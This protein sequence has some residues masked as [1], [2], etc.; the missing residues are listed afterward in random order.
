MQIISDIATRFRLAFL[1][2]LGIVGGVKMNVVAEA[3]P[4][5]EV[6]ILP[7]VLTV[8]E[9]DFVS[10]ALESGGQVGGTSFTLVFDPNALTYKQAEL[11]AG[12]TNGRLTV[13][14]RN[15]ADGQLGIVL[16]L[17]ADQT[18]ASGVQE[19]VRAEFD[20]VANVT[21]EETTLSFSDNPVRQLFGDVSANA[22]SGSFQEGVI[23]VDRLIQISPID[24]QTVP[25]DTVVEIPFAVTGR[26]SVLTTTPRSSDVNLVPVENMII[27]G[28]GENRVLKVT[29]RANVSGDVELG[30]VLTDGVEQ[31]VE[32]FRLT[33][34]PVNDPP[35]INPIAKVTALEN[36]GSVEI[37]LEGI[38]S[39]AA[40][41]SQLITISASSSDTK[42][43]PFIG[44]S[45]QSPDSTGTLRVRSNDNLNGLGVIA[46]TVTDDGTGNNSTTIEFE[47]EVTS[48]NTAPVVAPIPA[49]SI[50]EE[51]RSAVTLRAFDEDIP[52]DELRFSLGDGAPEGV[53]IDPV[54]GELSWTPTEE[55]GPGN[56]DISVIVTDDGTPP[57][58]TEQVFSVQVNEVN[59]APVLL[60]VGDRQAIEDET[61]EFTLQATDPD[62]PLN[63]LR[64]EILK[65][66]A[67]AQLDPISGLFSWTPRESDTPG[68]IEV[69]VGVRDQGTVP[70]SDSHTFFID[71]KAVNDGP[72]LKGPDSVL[73]DEDGEI[74][75]PDLVLQDSD[76]GEGNGRLDLRV[77]HGHL[78]VPIAG[79]D[80]QSALEGSES[81][82]STVS[83]VGGLEELQRILGEVVYL[84]NAN[85]H[86]RDTLV[87]EVSDE[88]N[89]GSGGA[90]SVS[91][92]VPIT[93]KSIND[94]PV[95]GPAENRE[96]IAG[97]VLAPVL[98]SVSDIEDAL[99]DL[100]FTATS[101][102]ESLVPDRGIELEPIDDF[103][104][105]TIRPTPRA[106]GEA[107]IRL[108]VEDL[109]GATAI[110]EFR[111]AMSGIAP[112]LVRQSPGKTVFAG[113]DVSFGVEVDGT[114]PF[115][116]TWLFAATRDEDPVVI[117]EAKQL[118]LTLNEVSLENVGY[119]AARV[120]NA[121]GSVV[122]VPV[123]LLVN[124]PPV[125]TTQPADVIASEGTP[126]RLEMDFDRTMAPGSLSVV[127][128]KD[129]RPLADFSGP[130]LSKTS[131]EVSD[132][133]IYRATVIR[134]TGGLIS[135]T[136]S[137]EV[138]V[139]VGR[140]PRITKELTEPGI[141][142]VTAI[143][144]RTI[145]ASFRAIGSEPF[146]VSWFKDDE[147]IPG[148]DEFT[149]ELNAVSAAD[150]ASYFARVENAFGTASTRPVTLV[151]LRPVSEVIVTT[152]PA[153][154]KEGFVNVLRGGTL[155]LGL[156]FN[157]DDEGLAFRW[158]H[159]QADIEGANTRDLT[160]A[161]IG[162]K[163]SGIYQAVI[164]NI[165][166]VP[167]KS[168]PVRV[169]VVQPPSFILQP[170]GRTA[171]TGEN[172]FFAVTV[173]GS[174][175][176]TLQ[177]RRDGVDLPGETGRTLL[178][179]SVDEAS[180]GIY[181][182]VATS[183][184]GV[185][186]TSGGASLVVV[187]RPGIGDLTASPQVV[188]DGA[189]LTLSVN[190]TGEGPFRIQWQKNGANLPGENGAQHVITNFNKDDAGAYTVVVQNRAG[191]VTSTPINVVPDFP[192]INLADDF[193]DRAS[194]NLGSGRFV[195]SNAQATVEAGEPVDSSQFFPSV[196]LTWEAPAT[197]IAEFTTAGS[198]FDTLLAVST[199][200]SLGA[201]NR[202]ARDNDSGGFLTSR[203]QFDAVAGQ[204]YQIGIFGFRGSRGDI[205][206]CWDL[207]ESD[208][209]L[210]KIVVQPI[211]VT[212]PAG[213]VAS[214]SVQA[215]VDQGT[216]LAYQ[217]FRNGTAIPGANA[218][219]YDI[220]SVEFSDVGQYYVSIASI[221]GAGPVP[222]DAPSVDSG[223]VQL[224][225][226]ENEVRVAN[227]FPTP[228]QLQLN[229]GVRPGLQQL[230]EVSLISAI[231]L[232][233]FASGG[234]TSSQI[235]S[236]AGA[237]K[238]PG[239]PN[240]CGVI[241]GA[242][243]WLFFTPL[244]DGTIR[245][246][247][248]GS[249]FDTVLAVYTGTSFADIVEVACDDNSGANGLTSVVQFAATAG[250]TYFVAVDGVDGAT[251]NV[252][253]Q[254]DLANP[255]V[256]LQQPAGAGS[257]LAQQALRP[258]QDAG[259]KVLIGSGESTS[260][261]VVAEHEIAS[262]DLVYIWQYSVDQAEGSFVDLIEETSDT[263]QLVEIKAE[264]AGFYRVLVANYAGM[265]TSQSVEVDV[266][267]PPSI[268]DIT[269]D[270]TVFPGSDITLSVAV[271]GA[272]PLSY[273]WSFE[274]GIIP[275]E[276][277]AA[278]PL[279][280][281]VLGNTGRYE[282]TISNS[283]GEASGSVLLT[284][285]ELLEITQQP[286]SQT[287]NAGENITFAVTATGGNLTY[288]WRF[289]GSDID[290]ATSSS[291]TIEGVSTANAGEYS[292]VVAN[293]GQSQL[294][295]P[296]TL[297]VS[298]PLVIITQPQDESATVGSSVTLSVVADG[299]PAPQYQWLREGAVLVG[300]TGASLSLSELTAQD[301]GT[302]QVQV[303]NG[304]ETLNSA[305]A[306]L[307]VTEEETLRFEEATFDGDGNFR[308]VVIGTV[309]LTYQ[310]ERSANLVDWQVLSTFTFENNNVEFIDTEASTLGRSYY[311]LVPQ[312]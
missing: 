152:D 225:I 143:E 173:T 209:P 248:E 2:A 276:T 133:G 13:N 175:A 239:E 203:V 103:V 246:S 161:N 154:D 121:L 196:W 305:L 33:L 12:A 52:A 5:P 83:L 65:G 253:L 77:T 208:L 80:P 96:G 234:F 89:S 62:R 258:L 145:A 235:F 99:G 112:T 101:S 222:P 82:S 188:G 163:Q 22:I 150:A 4:A 92:E 230:A 111:V 254:S 67:G 151:V 39:G 72:V 41:E 272:E 26:T 214:F 73:V 160:I 302:Y 255:P 310:L 198:G 245:L 291:L 294:S 259:A 156:Q 164:N 157:G 74:Q 15:A 296:A 139:R 200:D 205:V 19:I 60:S 174:G 184:F 201:L 84:P 213:G 309:G 277:E 215:D 240:H 256:I 21:V 170:L 57:A 137:R 125:I 44:V 293:E 158:Q 286:V 146:A 218:A 106:T 229:G 217:W 45:Y 109:D 220:A 186:I 126:I 34:V 159:K 155:Q 162:V 191:A 278:L 166:D 172:V 153:A 311:R 70:L 30:V 79:L 267:R 37:A 223:L 47:F 303:S 216:E 128:T 265:V 179:P 135:E 141:S 104:R 76:L 274:G 189:N 307:T 269:Q 136:V 114:A 87:I 299:N 287:T 306:I 308:L 88:G 6:R 148:A 66:P 261:S 14:D 149:L 195:S 134:D 224:V 108:V 130:I 59:Q 185:G 284:L 275:G 63:S 264:D 138:R 35:S 68:R 9:P 187:D 85:Y 69:E 55:Q 29:P 36:Q 295:D 279:T 124:T 298:V 86:G 181:D 16:V 283:V 40:D 260:F 301:A 169:R 199:G 94:E 78:T 312:P 8:G 236:T 54:S 243:Q 71:V 271:E 93:V 18:F 168:P 171:A 132:S 17:G 165:A 263:L 288:Q 43:I 81:P 119:Y 180:E 32:T 206:L 252:S 247:T 178:L 20:P 167:V 285:D 226:A 23:D 1:V 51:V 38:T 227:K 144:G 204:Q 31:T 221:D 202:V 219:S 251:G 102:D 75:I 61:L 177:W 257:A 49:A 194:F 190:P 98:V 7:R 53:S 64:F 27:E 140:P 120:S 42:L 97:S 127:W 290:G 231:E 237:F 304:V 242:S 50:D 262:S 207:E 58:Q 270:K 48:V 176:T 142:E 91:M 268:V 233:G 56:Y 249:E 282:V 300:A 183:S 110:R 116:V 3:L 297:N 273:Q 123:Q 25:E 244:S 122:S 281:L 131:A 238:E 129:G 147:L 107:I 10:I 113:A 95:F 46:V 250:V 266:I 115:E 292:V 24:D 210:P 105:V 280:N 117:A 232:S 192:T 11:G 241:G 193:A 182:V 197:G 228:D 211:D 90:V 100:T 118:K 289:Q 28:D 212:T